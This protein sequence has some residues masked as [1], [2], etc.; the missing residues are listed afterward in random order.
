MSGAGAAFG[1]YALFAYTRRRGAR[2]RC[3]S[4]ST[5][6]PQFEGCVNSGTHLKKSARIPG[7]RKC[8]SEEEERE[9]AN[10]ACE[11][12]QNRRDAGPPSF[13]IPFTIHECDAELGVSA[14]GDFPI[15]SHDS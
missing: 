11:S 4:V 12:A 5:A 6:P 2:C 1:G 3:P 14:V 8:R 10:M 9:D 13:P 15:V 7:G